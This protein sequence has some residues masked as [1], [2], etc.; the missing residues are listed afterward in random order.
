MFKLVIWIDLNAQSVCTYQLWNFLILWCSTWLEDSRDHK[1]INFGWTELKIWIKQVNRRVW[2]NLKMISNW[3]LKLWFINAL[4]DSTYSKD[5]NGMLFVK[6]WVTDQKI[7]IIK[8]LDEIWC[9]NLIWIRFKSEE[10][11]W[12]VLIWGY[13]FMRISDQNRRIKRRLDAPD[14]LVPLRVSDLFWSS[15]SWSDGSD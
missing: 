2:F 3:I 10:A 4:L 13:R 8:V 1:F 9:Q 7:W 5:S 14:C 12:R 11:T 6:F 15:G